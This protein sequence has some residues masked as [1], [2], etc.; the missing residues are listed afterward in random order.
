[1]VWANQCHHVCVC[2]CLLK[3]TF[4]LTYTLHITSGYDV[5]QPVVS[6]TGYHGDVIDETTGQSLPAFAPGA[7]QGR[8]RP[9]PKKTQ[10]GNHKCV[11]VCVCV[12]VCVYTL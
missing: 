2:V 12:C 1:V 4:V 3:H 11:L 5:D 7:I 9:T 8:P 6:P 10:S